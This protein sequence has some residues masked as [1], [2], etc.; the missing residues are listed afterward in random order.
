MLLQ[1]PDLQQAGVIDFLLDTGAAVTCLHPLD[2]RSRIEVERS[3]LQGLQ[4][5][6]RLI[7]VVGIGGSVSYYVTRATYTFRQEDGHQR[8]IDGQIQI[9][10]VRREVQTLPSLLGWDVLQHFRIVADWAAREVT[11]DS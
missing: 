1:L 5:W 6:G 7:D 10:Q 8:S 2:A 11:L 4:P 9:A 3:Q